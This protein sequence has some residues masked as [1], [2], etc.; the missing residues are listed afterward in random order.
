MILLAVTVS[1]ITACGGRGNTRSPASYDRDR[2]SAEEIQKLGSALT[3]YDV[4]QQLRPAW[5][6]RRGQ[7]GFRGSTPIV[8][9]VG[10]ARTGSVE[11]LREIRREAILEI[12]HLDSVAATQVYGTGHSSGAIV[13]TLR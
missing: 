10:G 4:I 11:R 8:V 13:V 6:S 12:R 2:V 9:Y 7:T 3:A 1:L 5:F